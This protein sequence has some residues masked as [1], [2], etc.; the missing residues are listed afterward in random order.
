L[1]FFLYFFNSSLYTKKLYFLS[2]NYLILALFTIS[3]NS[4]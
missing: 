2:P 3:I 4:L 1:I